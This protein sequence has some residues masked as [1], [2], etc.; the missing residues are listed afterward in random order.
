MSRHDSLTDLNRK[1]SHNR[2]SISSKRSDM[3]SV[4]TG[5]ECWQVAKNH[6]GTELL[7]LQLMLTCRSPK[8]ERQND[9]PRIRCVR[10][11]RD[12]FHNKYA[13]IMNTRLHASDNHI[14]CSGFRLDFLFS[15]EQR[16]RNASLDFAEGYKWSTAV[17]VMLIVFGS[18]QN[19]GPVSVTFSRP[20]YLFIYLSTLSVAQNSVQW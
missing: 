3:C 9:V 6:V 12:C 5:F 15:V 8:V 1:Y 10:L 19:T 17:C 11:L 7:H 4:E 13:F 2:R 20:V 16:F 14:D 18:V